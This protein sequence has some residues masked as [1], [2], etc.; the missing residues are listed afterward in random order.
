MLEAKSKSNYPIL[1]VKL[2]GQSDEKCIKRIQAL[3]KDQKQKK[4]YL[5]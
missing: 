4:N 1:K 5:Y 2:G 3:L